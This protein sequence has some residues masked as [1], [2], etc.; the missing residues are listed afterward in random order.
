M[1]AYPVVTFIC[2]AKSVGYRMRCRLSTQIAISF[3]G[4]VI[5]ALA[6][7]SCSGGD[8]STTEVGSALQ[9]SSTENLVSGGGPQTPPCGIFE[10]TKTEVVSGQQFSVGRYQ[11]NTF[12]ISCDEVMGDAGL[13]SQFLQLE[14]NEALPD[15]WRFLEGAIGA[16]KFVSGPAVGFRVQRISD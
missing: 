14:D 13:F 8:T 7:S 9:S 15:P 16:P 5:F 1:A 4:L 11:I 12:G 3:C 6:L 10:V 2:K